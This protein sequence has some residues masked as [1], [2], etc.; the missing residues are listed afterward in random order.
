LF[1]IAAVE[2]T[3]RHMLN[4]VLAASAAAS[5]AGVTPHAM[6]DAL[7]GFKG[8]EHV[9]EPA[10]E[11]RGAKKLP[12]LLRCTARYVREPEGDTLPAV[13][14]TLPDGADCR[15]DEPGAA[16]ALSEEVAYDDDGQLI[17][18]SLADYAIPTAQMLPNF[19]LDRTETP[20]PT[21]PLGVKGIGEAGTIAAPPAVINAIVDAVSH[22]GVTEIGKP[23]TPERVWKAIRDA[24]GGAA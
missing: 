13:T 18:G 6:T 24:K 2:L 17:T 3:G 8:L 7:R 16:Q 15:S 1:P 11:I 14:I 20:S 22:L 5:I 21:N 19:E 23:A 10:G 4:N 12:A 9:M